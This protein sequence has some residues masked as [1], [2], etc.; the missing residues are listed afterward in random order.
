MRS[1]KPV[2]TTTR[3]WATGLSFQEKLFHVKIHHCQYRKRIN[4]IH[5]FRHYLIPIDS[6]QKYNCKLKFSTGIIRSSFTWFCS[7]WHR[8]NDLA[9]AS[10]STL[11]SRYRWCI[12]TGTRFQIIANPSGANPT[13]M[14]TTVLIWSEFFFLWPRNSQYAVSN[15]TCSI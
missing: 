15:Y 9:A 2:S 6:F 13:T 1:R 8:Q 10:A 14:P 3:Y 12:R 4:K 5:F 7:F 11:T